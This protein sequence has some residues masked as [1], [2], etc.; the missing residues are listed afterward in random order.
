MYTR[1]RERERE[2]ETERHGRERRREGRE[3]EKELER[4]N[5]RERERAVRGRD[6]A[7]CGAEGERERERE[8]EMERDIYQVALVVSV[9]LGSNSDKVQLQPQTGVAS[10]ARVCSGVQK[11]ALDALRTKPEMLTTSESFRK[12]TLIHYKLQMDGASM[13]LILHARAKL[14]YRV[15]RMMVAWPQSHVKLQ[16][17][18]ASIE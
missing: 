1:S 17:S 6:R 12:S 18:L 16:Q 14:Y 7:R 15:G 4:E 2:R 5:E 13:Q 10:V 8:R 9:Y 3:R 11:N